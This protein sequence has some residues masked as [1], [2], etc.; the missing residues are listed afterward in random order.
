[1][2]G[3]EMTKPRKSTRTVDFSDIPEASVDQLDAL[4]RFAMRRGT[5]S[6]SASIPAEPSERDSREGIRRG[7]ANARVGRTMPAQRVFDELRR[8]HGI[9]QHDGRQ[10]LRTD[11]QA[12]FDQLAREEAQAFNK[13]S[14]RRLAKRIKSRGRRSRT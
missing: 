7:L 8:K 4:R 11:V 1:M 13:V 5:P 10:R 9:S 12:G 3:E 14:G 2:A 6:P